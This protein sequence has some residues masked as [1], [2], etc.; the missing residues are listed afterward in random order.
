MSSNDSVPD[1]SQK[2]S[3]LHV[4]IAC[5]GTGGHLFPGIAVAEELL[6]RGHSSTLL[7]SEKQIDAIASAGSSHLRFEK[8]PSRPMPKPWSPKIFGFIGDFIK[9][10]GITKRLIRET[11]ASCVLGMGG[12]TSTA[13]LVAGKSCKLLTL[14]HESNAIPGRANRLNARFSN[15]ALVGWEACRKYFPEDKVIVTGTPVRPA[16]LDL[17]DKTAARERFGLDPDRFTLLVMGGSQGARGIN[18]AVCDMLSQFKPDEMQIL[19]ISGP[20]D[21]ELVQSAYD[22]SDIL[23]HVVP[24]LTDFEWAY[25]AADLTVCRSGASSLTEMSV[26]GL[27]GILIPYPHAADDHQAKNAAVFADAQASVILPQS[28]LN[29]ESLAASVRTVGMDSAKLAQMA[30]QMRKQA[31]GSVSATIVDLIESKSTHKNS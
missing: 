20:G 5:G 11:D 30:E 22:K 1:T 27:P 3:S 8:L 21:E 29:G 23:A 18:S 31:P 19:H 10:R 6:A 24:F 26:I 16:M 9:A 15:H 4:L 14:I 7:I 28:E 13:P 12:F 25:A 17:P 2:P